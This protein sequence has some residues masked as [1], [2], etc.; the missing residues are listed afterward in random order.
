LKMPLS[1]PKALLL[2]GIT[3]ALLDYKKNIIKFK[4]LNKIGIQIAYRVPNRIG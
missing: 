1:G 2:V 3:F 4:V